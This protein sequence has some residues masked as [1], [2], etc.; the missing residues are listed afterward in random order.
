MHCVLRTRSI[1]SVDPPVKRIAV[2]YFPDARRPAT[3]P[4]VTASTD[5]FGMVMGIV[6]RVRQLVRS[7]NPLVLSWCFSDTLTRLSFAIHFVHARRRGLIQF[8]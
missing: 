6:S 2:T 7:K 1:E 8:L 4:A 5:T 3:L